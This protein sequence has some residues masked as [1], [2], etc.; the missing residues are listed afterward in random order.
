MKCDPLFL[1][2]AAAAAVAVAAV[3]SLQQRAEL[4]QLEWLLEQGRYLEEY[5]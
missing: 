3:V 5:C 1:A 2:D 4:G